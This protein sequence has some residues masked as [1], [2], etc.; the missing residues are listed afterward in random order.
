[1]ENAERIL[2][3]A[4][5]MCLGICMFFSLFRAVRGPRPMDRVVGI[6]MTN[7]LAMLCLALCAFL[8]DE[9]W[10]LDVC[11]IYGMISFL[12]V[13]VLSMLH[14]DDSRTGGKDKKEVDSDD[15]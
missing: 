12:A 15:L 5:L 6:N 9:S 3:I 4:A 8:L 10:L 7:T 1:M 11:L 14:I 13:T 2:Y